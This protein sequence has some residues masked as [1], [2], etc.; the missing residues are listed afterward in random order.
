MPCRSSKPII[1]LS[2]FGYYFPNVV[3][4]VGASFS[5]KRR[6]SSS[7]ADVYNRQQIYNKYTL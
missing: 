1:F 5:L 4:M 2:F 7:Y 3:F 6:A